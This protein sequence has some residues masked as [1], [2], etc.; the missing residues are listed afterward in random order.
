[1]ER[2]TRERTLSDEQ[3]F[4]F[5][6]A[7]PFCTISWFFEG[8][9]FLVDPSNPTPSSERPVP[10]ISFA[11][12][13][14]KPMASW[15]PGVV[16]ALTVGIYPEAWKQL[17]ESDLETLVDKTLPLEDVAS[18]ALLDLC[19]EVLAG[20]KNET[21]FQQFMRGLGPIWISS[22]A[23]RLRAYHRLSDWTHE[24]ATKAASSGTGKSVRQAQRRIKSWTGQNQRDLQIYARNEA[25][26]ERTLAAA[27]KGNLDLA[28]IALD[29]GFSDQAHM[30]RSVR[31]LTGMSPA[32]LNQLIATAEAFW[33]YR[34][35]GERF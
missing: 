29:A 32:K 30:G 15:N 27:L 35:I 2:D 24:L 33:C 8:V 18:G 4:N 34:L 28:E 1:M 22:R 17:V 11:G 23:P 31:K 21:H 13:Q 7:S 9:S 5:F 16:H 6:P 12:P 3:R 19:K 20:P 25:L 26:F 14:T 10:Q